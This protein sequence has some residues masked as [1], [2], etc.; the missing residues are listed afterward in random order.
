MG[1]LWFIGWY[2]EK[3]AALFI[4]S[5]ELAKAFKLRERLMSLKVWSAKR[6]GG[7]L[8]GAGCSHCMMAAVQ[9]KSSN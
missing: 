5:L 4:F 8:P 1:E 3:L 9:A 2:E 7:G 6:D